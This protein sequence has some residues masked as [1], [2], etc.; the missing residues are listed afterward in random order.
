MSNSEH[1][2]ETE[3][4]TGLMHLFWICSGTFSG[5]HF[6]RRPGIRQ[7]T[8]GHADLLWQAEPGA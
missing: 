5:Q 7:S 6:I 3:H 1:I 8:P 4:N 2:K